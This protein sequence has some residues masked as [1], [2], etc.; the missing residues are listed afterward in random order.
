MVVQALLIQFLDTRA[1]LALLVDA[2]HTSFIYQIPLY[3]SGL[4]S[5]V[6]DHGIKYP[7]SAANTH[8]SNAFYACKHAALS[9]L[10]AAFESRFWFCTLYIPFCFSE[11]PIFYRVTADS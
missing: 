6:T 11:E 2:S 5:T 4:F 9:I 10:T 7:N 1:L 8:K 3:Y